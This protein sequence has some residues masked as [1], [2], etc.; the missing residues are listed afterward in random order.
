MLHSLINL[1]LHK[2]KTPLPKKQGL[3]LIGIF[4]IGERRELKTPLPKKQ[5][6]KLHKT[7]WVQGRYTHLKPHFQKNKD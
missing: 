7:G 4:E 6:L 2:L 5:G 3:K 1:G